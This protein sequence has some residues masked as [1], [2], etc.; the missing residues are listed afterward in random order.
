MAS[1]YQIS[2]GA[3]LDTV[4][5]ALDGGTAASATGFKNASNADLNTLYHAYV[6]GAKASTT[7]YQ[8]AAGTDLKDI[9]QNI[10]VP[11]LAIGGNWVDTDTALTSDGVE[12]PGLAYFQFYSTG[13]YDRYQ[14]L[15]NSS[16]TWLTST[17]AGNGSGFYIKAVYSGDT[18]YAYTNMTSGTWY[19]MST[20]TRY[21]GISASTI[22]TKTINA[23]VS[24]N[25]SA[26]DTGAEVWTGT[27]SAKKSV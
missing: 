27:F 8:I 12:D 25:D 10:S 15:A 7:G 16:R 5:L 20:T 1:G 2:T 6:S 21:V 14:E 24:I 13:A 11:I 3:D 18:A 19:E 23:T 17:G 4:F 22:T 26:S 9:F